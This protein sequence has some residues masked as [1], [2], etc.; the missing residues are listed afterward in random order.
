MAMAEI[1]PTRSRTDP[2]ALGQQQERSQRSH[3]PRRLHTSSFRSKGQ[4]GDSSD[5]SRRHHSHRHHAKDTVQSAIELKPPISFD[6]LL[7]RDKK[8][9]PDSS[10]E[11]SGTAAQLQADGM[12]EREEERI[13]RPEDVAKAKRENTDREEQLRADLKGVEEVGMSSTRQLDDTYYAI[14]E[15]TSL[16]RSTVASLQRLADES[17][18]MHSSF[19]EDAAKLEKET[20]QSVNSFGNF[21]PQEKTINDLVDNL[22][23][24]KD[25][26]D[27]LNNRLESARLRVEAFE[28]RET[29]KLAKRR[30]R[31]RI[32]WGTLLGV[33]AL[34]FAILLARNRRRV[35]L[36]LDTVGQQL[37]RIGD[38]MEDVAAPLSSRFRPS[39]TV[40]PYLRHLFDDL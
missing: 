39:S 22:Q 31:W 24:S 20:Q 21:S 32:T 34:I 29:A 12:Q 40:D 9:S 38:E 14:L 3:I 26:T 17:K 18:R 28:Q 33:V 30:T 11:A 23:G 25:R 5:N 1:A 15:K 36:Q 16:L 4:F 6:H 7:R 13:I 35:G 10:R 8:Y 37:A 19:K 27:G 2:T